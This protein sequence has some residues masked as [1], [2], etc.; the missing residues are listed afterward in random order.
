MAIWL[1][2]ALAYD[3]VML[4]VVSVL[5]DHTIEKSL[6]VASLAN[7]IDLVRI[8]LLLQFDVSALMGYT[9]AVFQKFF[10]GV[11][12]MTVIGAALMAWITVPLAAGFVSFNRK[13]F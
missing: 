8:A 1:L 7:P 13:D 2:L 12:G 3:G 9:G 10:S 6:L 5:A 4:F 11:V